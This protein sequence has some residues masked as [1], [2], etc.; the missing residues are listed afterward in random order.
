[1]TVLNGRGS[2]PSSSVIVLAGGCACVGAVSPARM[3][4]LMAAADICFLPSTHEGVA[5]T[6]YEAMAHEAV[7]VGA[8]VGGQREVADASTAH[9]AAAAS[10]RRAGGVSVCGGALDPDSPAGDC[11]A[12]RCRRARAHRGSCSPPN[13]WRWA[14]KRRSHALV[15]CTTS[16]RA[17][18]FRPPWRDL[19]AIRAIEHDR[20]SKLAEEL[21][22]HTPARPPSRQLEAGGGS[23][24]SANAGG[25]SRHTRGG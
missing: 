14:W 3:S 1:M 20:L 2:A 22:R 19:A 6:L 24:C 5:L 16:S 18:P 12:A 25:S 9:S 13:R 4:E 10:R 8:D 11:P 17:P 15:V 21:W 7:F 23:G